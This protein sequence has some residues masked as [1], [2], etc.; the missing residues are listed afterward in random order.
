MANQIEKDLFLQER[1]HLDAD[2]QSGK[3]VRLV[4]DLDL[5]GNRV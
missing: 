2:G 3:Q 4:N 1:R 5:M